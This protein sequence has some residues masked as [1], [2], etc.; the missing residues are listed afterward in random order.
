MG[1]TIE[2]LMMAMKQA[3]GWT[4]LNEWPVALVADALK[5]KLVKLAANDQPCKNLCLT[6]K[7]KRLGL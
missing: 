3:D 4:D 5:L 1:Q 7:G 2:D 6:A